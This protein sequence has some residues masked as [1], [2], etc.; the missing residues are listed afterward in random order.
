M[1]CWA[2]QRLTHDDR[3]LDGAAEASTELSGATELEDRIATK[4]GF[5]MYV[6]FAKDGEGGSAETGPC[7]AKRCYGR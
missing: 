6:A 3:C 4:G 5:L 7:E 1:L 2:E